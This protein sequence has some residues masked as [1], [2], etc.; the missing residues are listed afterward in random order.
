MV[1]YDEAFCHQY[2]CE[3]GCIITNLCTICLCKTGFGKCIICRRQQFYQE[4]RPKMSEGI[5]SECVYYIP[6][7]PDP[8]IKKPKYGQSEI[9]QLLSD[10]ELFV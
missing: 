2:R 7:I 4:I 6:T 8:S 9:D 10:I 1:C 3:Y 5:K